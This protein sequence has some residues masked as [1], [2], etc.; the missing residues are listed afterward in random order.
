MVSSNFNV[1]V[2]DP[3]VYDFYTGNVIDY[4]FSDYSKTEQ[5]KQETTFNQCAYGIENAFILPVNKEAFDP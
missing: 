3:A 4:C 1:D 5:Y 2:G